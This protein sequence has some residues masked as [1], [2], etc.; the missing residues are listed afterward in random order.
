MEASSV[1][2]Q[3]SKRKDVK[4]RSPQL[5]LG[6]LSGEKPAKIPKPKDVKEILKAPEEVISD[7]GEVFQQVA[8]D[9]WPDFANG[10]Q[11]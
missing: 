9:Y 4:T 5:W 2:F 10:S 8:S 11:K 1:V 6:Q 7:V 3:L